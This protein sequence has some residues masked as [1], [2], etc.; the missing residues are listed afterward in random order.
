MSNLPHYWDV[1]QRQEKWRRRKPVLVPSPFGELLCFGIAAIYA[2]MTIVGF[3]SHGNKAL[4]PLII[5][6]DLSCAAIG[7]LLRRK[8]IQV[9]RLFDS[10]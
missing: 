6:V 9:L 8:R 2:S 1:V 10:A 3:M 7:V 4:V 5:V